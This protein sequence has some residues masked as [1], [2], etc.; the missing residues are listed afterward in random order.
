MFKLPCH[1]DEV[2]HSC[3]RF[4]GNIFER[5]M[6]L[7]QTTSNETK[8]KDLSIQIMKENI[9]LNHASLFLPSKTSTEFLESSFFGIPDD[10]R[11]MKEFCHYIA[12]VCHSK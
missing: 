10:S 12:L 4:L 1:F 11:P 3:V 2:F 7:N 6:S 9:T 8:I 5:I